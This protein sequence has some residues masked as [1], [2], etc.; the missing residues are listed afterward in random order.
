[1]LLSK[2]LEN[3]YCLLIVYYQSLSVKSICTMT[4]EEAVAISPARKCRVPIDYRRQ[5]YQTNFYEM[6]RTC[7]HINLLLQEIRQERNILFKDEALRRIKHGEES[8]YEA[9]Q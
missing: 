9:V 6:T 8:F 3:I 5:T 1:M 2:Q 4:F 7:P